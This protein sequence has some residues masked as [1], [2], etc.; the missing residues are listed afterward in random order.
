[1]TWCVRIVPC[2]RWLPCYS[3]A[4]EVGCKGEL[5]GIW[6]IHSI[7]GV[8]NESLVPWTF[9]LVRNAFPSCQSCCCSAAKHV[10]I[11][12]NLIL[13]VGSAQSEI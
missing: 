1:M 9:E 8:A 5:R 6:S 12:Q 2:A 10:F 4:F 11:G 13:L 7:G 3:I